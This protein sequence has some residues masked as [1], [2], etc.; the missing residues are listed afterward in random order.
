M[1]GRALL[2]SAV[3]AL[4]QPSPVRA[5]GCP[6]STV[7]VA[8]WPVV[9]SPSLPGFTLRLPRTFTRHA[10][11]SSRGATP[12]SQWTAATHARLTITHRDPKAGARV[13]P[14][15]DGRSDYARCE[16]RVGIATATVVSYAN[17]PGAATYVVD[18]HIRWPDGEALDLRADASD[19]EHLAQLLAALRTIRRA[20]A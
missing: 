12:S 7:D 6:A 16:E 4:V 19:R 10:P 20:G 8:N 11:S 17:A 13:F 2:V 15:A 5:D 18:A 9:R 14:P 1:I 3:L